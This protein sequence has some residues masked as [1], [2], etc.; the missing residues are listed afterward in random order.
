MNALRKITIRFLIYGALIGYLLCDLFVFH[1]PIARRID[2]GDPLSPENIAKAKANGV[3]ARV[4]G[5]NITRSQLDRAVEERLWL[6]GADEPQNPKARRLLRYA[7]LNDLIDHELLRT[8]CTAFAHDIT[9]SD[10]EIDARFNRFRNR[11]PNEGSMIAAM[12]SQGIR[13]KSQLR[14]RLTAQLQQEKYVEL[15]IGPLSQVTEEEAQAWF[16]EHQQELAQPETIEVRH[17]FLPSLGFSDE[18]AS[19]KLQL[20]LSQLQNRSKDFETLAREISQDSTSNQNGGQIG[21]VSRKQLPDDLANAL[22]KLPQQQATIIQSRIGWHLAEVTGHRPARPRS[23]EETRNEVIAAITTIKRQ[24][25]ANKF[26]DA[27]RQFEA[28][29]ITIFHDMVE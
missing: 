14:D 15:K 21:W 5:Y 7:A 2:N 28:A 25:A 29:R 27:L 12:N 4:F 20:A 10:E 9:V 19:G 3:V 13:S 11:F 24:A 22:F 1:G 16:A 23:Y 26:R 8:K 18:Q 17:L 6:S